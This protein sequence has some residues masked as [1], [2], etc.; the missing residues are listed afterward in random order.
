MRPKSKYI[1]LQ[2]ATKYCDYSQEYL[3]LRARQKKLKAVKIGRNW[4]TTMPWLNNYLKRVDDYN[5]IHKAN[6]I[7][8]PVKKLIEVKAKPVR[9]VSFL[10]LIQQQQ[11]VFAITLAFILLFI[12]SIF[13][14]S[15]NFISGTGNG[16]S[17]DV[18][19]IQQSVE[20]VMCETSKKFNRIT[21]FLD[22]TGVKTLSITIGNI[23]NS[24][25]TINDL[26]FE[27]KSVFFATKIEINSQKNSTT[28]FL[29]STINILQDTF[30][31]YTQWL[32]LK[33]ERTKQVWL[34]VE[35]TVEIEE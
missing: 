9:S 27:T 17:Q 5:K 2:D 25:K 1:S 15:L 12:G 32:N 3:S 19:E 29:A 21:Q 22:S 10:S 26:V 7:K 8:K 24:I 35:T 16:I 31:D 13:I 20:T 6:S 14:D 4:V 23:D 11:R 30:Q 18:S 28:Y 33:I 34:E